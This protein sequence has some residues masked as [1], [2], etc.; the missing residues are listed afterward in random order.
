MR[1]PIRPPTF[2]CHHI[3]VFEFVSN[4]P[5]PRIHQL[6]C[7]VKMNRTEPSRYRPLA[8]TV[9]TINHLATR[10]ISNTAILNSPQ[11][12]KGKPTFA[13]HRIEINPSLFIRKSRCELEGGRG[14][15][16]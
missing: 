14:H 2:S 3:H 4:Y 13:V 11:D 6:N 5:Q 8:H 1:K 7:Q 15:I 9:E 12:R 16:A 10:P